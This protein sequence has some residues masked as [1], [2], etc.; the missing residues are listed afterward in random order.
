MADAFDPEGVSDRVDGAAVGRAVAAEEREGGA[1]DGG[2][3]RGEVE[4]QVA[5]VGRALV[6]VEVVGQTVVPAGFGAA[7]DERVG[8]RGQVEAVGGSG[9]RGRD[10]QEADHHQRRCEP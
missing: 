1:G 6:D 3:E 4:L 10:E 8:H 2:A 7:L 9:R 5:H